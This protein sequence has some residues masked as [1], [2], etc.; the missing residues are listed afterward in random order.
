[1][2]CPKKLRLNAYV[3]VKCPKPKDLFE[4]IGARAQTGTGSNDGSTY[5]DPVLLNQSKMD[6]L[7]KAAQEERTRLYEEYREEM[8]KMQSQQEKENSDDNPQ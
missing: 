8:A 2:Y 1:M 6:L 4:R 7:G 5:S 3:A